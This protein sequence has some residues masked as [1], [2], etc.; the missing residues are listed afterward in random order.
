MGDVHNDGSYS[1][2]LGVDSYRKRRRRSRVFRFVVT[3]VLIAIIGGA[4][5]M[6]G[7]QFIDPDS[8]P[9]DLPGVSESNDVVVTEAEVE[10]TT[11]QPATIT[12]VAAGD[13]IPSGAVADSGRQESGAYDFSHL[14]T[15]LKRELGLFD[16]RIVN[17]EA[18]MAGERYGFGADNPLNAPQDL[19]R[20]E[21]AAGFNVV[22]RATDHT[23]DAQAEG[24]HNELTWWH[25]NIP[26]MA[27][28]G[29]AD[30]NPQNNPTL[31]DYNNNVYIF[32]KDGF[33]VAV[34]NHTSVDDQNK[35]VIS[36]L[37]ESKIASDV[38]KAREQGAEMIIACPHW[39]NE[40]NSEISEEQER[41]AKVYAEQGVDLIIGTHPRVLQKVDV[42][43]SP[44]GHKT[45]CF[46]SLGCLISPYSDDNLL[47]G[48]AEVKLTRDDH[49]ECKVDEAVLKTVIT[50]RENGDQYG[51]YLL[52]AYTDDIA[53]T[54]WD[55]WIPVDEWNRKCGELLGSDYDTNT[56]ELKVNLSG[57]ATPASEKD[58]EK[59][60]E[61]EEETEE[62]E[63]G[64]FEY[65]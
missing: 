19:G 65:V 50:H 5:Y 61:S 44:D 13:V 26:Q 49:G 63:D 11:V 20:A 4:S 8:L 51:T 15:H 37:S 58:D 28:L 55:A 43:E 6:F 33:K 25:D 48:L 10:P 38:A 39:G 56:C 30:P 32:E 54:S 3:L 60:D 59:K 34:L 64:F 16:L 52:S 17:Q 27:V 41:F 57:K 29:I 21:N 2:E 22:L 36:R 31:S 35:D 18:V 9:F 24:I 47:G 53:S 14:F 46:Y 62:V 1:R 23:L 40:N 7:K 42:L 45:V 12:V